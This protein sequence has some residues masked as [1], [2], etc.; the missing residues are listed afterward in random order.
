MADLA[1]ARGATQGLCSASLSFDDALARM[2]AGIVPLDIEHVPLRQAS[3]RVLARAVVATRS[4]PN[5]DLAA[6]D[7]Y[8]VRDIAAGAG[9]AMLAVVGQAAPGAPYSRMLE[10]GEA[11]RIFT[12]APT[13]DGAD[14]VIPQEL[15]VRRGSR[16]AVPTDA[17]PARHI[18]CRGSDFAAGQS[19]LPAGRRIDARA[20]LVAAAADVAAL[21]VYRR[22]RVS[23]LATGDEIRAAGSVTEGVHNIPDS[24]SPAVAALAEEWGA[25][26]IG[27]CPVPDRQDAIES[28]ARNALFGSDVL[29]VTGGASVGDRDF[30]RAA[31]RSIGLDPVF[32]TV[33]MKPGKPVWYGRVGG[34]HV[35]G[36]PGNPTAAVVTARLFLAPLLCALQGRPAGAAL[37]WQHLP[38]EAALPAC[39]PRET[40]LCGTR[41]GLSVRAIDRQFASGQASLAFANVLIRRRPASPRGEAGAT[42]ATLDF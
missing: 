22:P 34:T 5:R 30:S 19:L 15:V 26:V 41:E 6:M 14:R 11:V 36:L 1:V 38:L 13:P 2:A 39:G 18:R 31:L 32:D 21:P 9:M 4:S 27:I 40:F 25:A 20:I 24:V 12:G 29:V 33:A 35:L 42:A 37:R 17:G 16:V 3:G 28:A 8:A 7:G 23:L 10:P